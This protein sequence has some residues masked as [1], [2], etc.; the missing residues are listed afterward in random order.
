M[1]FQ[2]LISSSATLLLIA[3]PQSGM[4]HEDRSIT[5]PNA[6]GITAPVFDEP[7]ADADVQ[8]MAFDME[9]APCDDLMKLEP[10]VRKAFFIT[11]IFLQTEGSLSKI[12]GPDCMFLGQAER[13]AAIA[14][15][16]LTLGSDRESLYFLADMQALIVSDTSR[17]AVAYG[18]TMHDVSGD[19]VEYFLAHRDD[20]EQSAAEARMFTENVVPLAALREFAT[21]E[22]QGIPPGNDAA[23]ADVSSSSSLA[24][25]IPSNATASSTAAAQNKSA[26]AVQTS[27][28]PAAPG[29][30]DD[31]AVQGEETEESVTVAQAGSST[32][33]VRPIGAEPEPPQ[34]GNSGLWILMAFFAL[35]G[36]GVL[37]VVLKQQVSAKQGYVDE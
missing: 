18:L 26:V 22:I 31:T 1:R 2:A 29:Q 15:P 21:K 4:A 35:I 20:A 13:V 27:S 30:P 17:N 3:L 10:D 9:H 7:I 34:T 19:P 8:R 16:A 14:D 37:I 32:S 24:E 28:E 33:A 11:A 5:D 12:I 23:T 36:I 25:R 6:P